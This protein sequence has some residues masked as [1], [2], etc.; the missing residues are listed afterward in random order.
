MPLVSNSLRTLSAALIAA[1]L[2][3]AALVIGREI[4][5]PLALAGISCFIL[6]PAVRWLKR[7]SLPD[8]AAVA[9]VV[10]IVTALLIAGSIAL[11]SQLLS[12]AAELPAYRTN[13]LEKVH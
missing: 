6:V 2:I 4:L 11:S 1:A 7:M 8:G 9:S 3:I 13:V 5:V 10:V 12:L